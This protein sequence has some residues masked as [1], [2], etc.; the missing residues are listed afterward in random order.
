MSYSLPEV[1]SDLTAESIYNKIQLQNIEK[2]LKIFN[3]CLNEIRKQKFPCY[4]SINETDSLDVIN[5]ITAK[6]NSAG[7]KAG[8][9]SKREKVQSGPYNKTYVLIIIILK[10]KILCCQ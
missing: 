1:P 7:Y 3:S 4:V 6:L 5:S 8:R 2:A 9:V 10:L